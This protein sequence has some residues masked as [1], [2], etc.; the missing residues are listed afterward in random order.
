[1]GFSLPSFPLTVNIWRFGGGPGDPVDVIAAGN[2]AYGRRVM[3]QYWIWGVQDPPHSAVFACLLLPPFTDVQDAFNG[4]GPDTVE[5][6]AGSGRLYLVDM[7]D[8]LGKGFA[9]EHRFAML[10]KTGA[11]PSP[12]P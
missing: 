9:N 2:L 4:V 12:I 10:S 1:M 5:V 8:D 7:V 6:P 3:T 11:W